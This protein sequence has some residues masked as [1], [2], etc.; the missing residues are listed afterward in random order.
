MSEKLRDLTQICNTVENVVIFVSDSL[1]EDHLSKQIADRGVTASAISPSTYTASSIPSI[2]TGR[3]PSEHRVWNLDNILPERPTVFDIEEYGVNLFGPWRGIEK[4]IDRPPLQILNLDRQCELEALSEPFV[5]LHH[6]IGGHT[7]YYWPHH[8]WDDTPEFLKAHKNNP[9]K[10][11]EYYSMAVEASADRFLDILEAVTDRGILDRTL[12]IFT[13]D[14]GEMLGEPS[15]AGIFGHGSPIVPETVRVPVVFAGAGL[16]EGE[17]YNT[18]LSGTDIAPTILGAQ[19]RTKPS[20][21][22]GIDVWSTDPPANR[23]PRSEIWQHTK[24]VTYAVLNR[25]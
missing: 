5:F 7:P 23:T 25:C 11:R 1:R 15:R 4:Q 24:P 9:E 3:Y 16:P 22:A 10:L 6:D 21:M 8:R 12:L 18:L 17:K 20:D 13:S 2:F 19:G 14:H